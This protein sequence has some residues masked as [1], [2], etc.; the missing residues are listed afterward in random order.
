MSHRAAMVT[1]ELQAA[2]ADLAEQL[3]QHSEALQADLVN[4]G[5]VQVTRIDGAI[6]NGLPADVRTHCLLDSLGRRPQRLW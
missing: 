6:L 4:A 2:G 3:Q 5:L 1:E